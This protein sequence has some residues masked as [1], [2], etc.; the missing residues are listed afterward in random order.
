MCSNAKRK[1]YVQKN[2]EVERVKRKARYQEN[3]DYELSLH[4]EWVKNN[5]DSS[6]EINNRYSRSAK[7]R[8]AH[9]AAG[10]KRRATKLQATPDWAD[11]QAIKCMYALASKLNK[12]TGSNLEVDHIVPLQ[13]KNVCGLH[14]EHNL[15]LLDKKLNV[16]KSNKF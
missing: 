4:K 6:R 14:V 3:K 9:N 10:A 13:G 2:K 8:V 7:G 12:I 15:Q 11:Q 16:S 5:K 1:S